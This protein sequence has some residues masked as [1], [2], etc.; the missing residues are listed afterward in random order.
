MGADHR[1]LRPES[2]QSQVTKT[3][4]KRLSL[5]GLEVLHGRLIPQRSGGYTIV[6]TA[7]LSFQEQVSLFRGA[8]LIVSYH[9]AGL[10]NLCFVGEG[11]S[12]L[13][14]FSPFY[15]PDYFRVLAEHLGARYGCVSGIALDGRAH[16]PERQ[17][18]SQSFKLPLD[19]LAHAVESLEGQS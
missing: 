15:T 8:R 7:K 5:S 14:I 2:L 13:E 4:R 11:T 19:L 18:I 17:R 12:L 9:G 16:V 3:A 10:A 6:D 1:G